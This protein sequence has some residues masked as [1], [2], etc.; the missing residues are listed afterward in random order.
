MAVISG[1]GNKYCRFV[2]SIAINFGVNYLYNELI[3]KF[4]LIYC[5]LEETNLINYFMN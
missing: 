5:L 1:H 3:D 4:K 2:I